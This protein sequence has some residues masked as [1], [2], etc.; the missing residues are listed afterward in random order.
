[1]SLPRPSIR[2][3][4]TPVSLTAALILPVNFDPFQ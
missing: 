4:F 3:P 1:L 2:P